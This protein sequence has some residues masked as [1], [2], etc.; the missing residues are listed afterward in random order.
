MSTNSDELSTN[1]DE[2]SL[3]KILHR[4]SLVWEII[5]RAKNA[6][7]I[8]GNTYEKA[9]QT[10]EMAQSF[11]SPKRYCVAVMLYHFGNT[12]KYHTSKRRSRIAFRKAN[13]WVVRRSA[14]ASSNR[15]KLGWFCFNWCIWGVE[16]HN[17]QFGG[18]AHINHMRQHRMQLLLMQ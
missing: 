14:V 9:F 16:S 11:A 10:A 4:Y 17:F 15:F 12:N 2:L 5:T 13:E 8:V 18:V 6:D 7:R 3:T 1:S